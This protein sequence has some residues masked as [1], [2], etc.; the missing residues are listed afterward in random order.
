MSSSQQSTAASTTD[1]LD[2]EAVLNLLPRLLPNSSAGATA[3]TEAKGESGS[4]STSKPSTSEA[5]GPSTLLESQYEALAALSHAIMT[6]A[7]FKLVGLSEEDKLE[8]TGNDQANKLPARWNS[9]KESYSFR[10]THSN[11]QLKYLIKC[12][13]MAGKFVIHGTTLE[14][15]KICSLEI[16]VEDFTSASYF[17]LTTSTDLNKDPLWNGF[18]SRFRVKDLITR[19]KTSIVQTLIPGLVMKGYQETATDTRTTPGEGSRSDDRGAN[20]GG[21]G[22]GGVDPGYYPD[23]PSG[24]PGIGGIPG[25]PGVG[26]I[27]GLGRPGFIPR[28][29]IFGDPF[30]AEDPSPFSI[31][32]SDLDPFGGRI[33]G[34]GGIGG[35]GPFGGGIGGSTGGGMIVGPNHPMFRPPGVGG[36]GGGGGLY[37]GPQPLPRGSVPPGARFDPIGPFGPGHGSAPGAGTAHRPPPGQGRHTFPGEPDNDEAPPPGYMDMFM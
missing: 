21:I 8:T 12:M 14:T 1:V 34:F 7:G 17:P 6:A 16:G 25:V 36:I 18:I 3:A 4:S 26:G 35:P 10:Y 22:R 23:D 27:P 2:D 11:S 19:F 37:G 20:R 5:E 15:N 9:S 13:R 24:F 30:S 29:P 32:R 28:P 33:G 31:G